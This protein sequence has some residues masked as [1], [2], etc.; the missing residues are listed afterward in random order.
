[1]TSYSLPVVWTKGYHINCSGKKSGKK[2]YYLEENSLIQ[3][4]SLTQHT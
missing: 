3:G 4:S 2:A 1:M